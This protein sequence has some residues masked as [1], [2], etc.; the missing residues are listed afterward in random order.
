MT[1]RELINEIR[2]FHLIRRPADAGELK[3]A[4]SLGLPDD[5]IEFYRMTNGAFLHQTDQFSGLAQVGGRWWKWKILPVSDLAPVTETMFVNETSPL[6][7][8]CRSWFALVDVMD[9]DFL[10]IDTAPTRRG[11]VVDCFHEAVGVVG[12]TP[13]VALSFSEA[14]SK[15]L[16]SPEPFWLQDGHVE[17]GRH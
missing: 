11:Q 13:V 12:Y 17:Y 2:R 14:L 5:L 9:S 16:T 15:L 10:A 4:M 7:E 1:I 8:A 3:K 6:L